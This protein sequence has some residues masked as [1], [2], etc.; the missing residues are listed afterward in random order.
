VAVALIAAGAVSW[1]GCGWSGSSLDAQVRA[2]V[3]AVEAHRHTADPADAARFVTDYLDVLLSS[4]VA[5][6]VDARDL[7]DLFDTALT[8][9]TQDELF[10]RVVAAVAAEGE[11]H[12]EGLRP[13][14][15]E[16]AT[17][18]LA[19]IDE[20]V[21]A[22]FAS[23][24]PA[25]GRDYFALQDFLRETVRDPR[26]ADRLDR[27]IDDY[28]QAE[29]ARAPDSGDPRH[30]RLSQIGRVDALVDEARHD[31]ERDAASQA[32]DADA[33]DAA[34]TAD[35]DRRTEARTNWAVWVALDRYDSDA[36][37]RA[38]AQG[39]PFVDGA[40]A[41]RA[42]LG[43]NESEALRRWALSLAVGGGPTASD[44]GYIGAGAVDIIW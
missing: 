4:D 9:G 12:S 29:T 25:Q 28:G 21:S 24:D 37:V 16:A 32:E 39:Q 11:I 43:P 40:G 30:L 6:A 41:L 23:A 20:R 36:A 44:V 22:R 7:A 38:A 33:V 1:M 5:D 2:V 3:D 13:V 8:D 34:D 17:A 35:G 26:A 31:A 27:A 14:F 18:R 42:D 10:G 15:A 19:W